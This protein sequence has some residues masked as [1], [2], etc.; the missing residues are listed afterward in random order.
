MFAP[1]SPTSTEYIWTT[2]GVG[3]NI[4]LNMGSS[5]S[6]AVQVSLTANKTNNSQAAWEPIPLGAQAPEVP[7]VVLLPAAGG[8][9]L[10]A[11]TVRD[12]RRKQRQISNER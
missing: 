2:L 6:S 1:T 12:R 4:V 9:L 8:V 5:V 7:V 11:A 10:V 3:S